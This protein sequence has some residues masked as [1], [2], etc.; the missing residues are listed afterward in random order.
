LQRFLLIKPR[1]G[2]RRPSPE[3][4]RA[5]R[6]R[7]VETHLESL[8]R[9]LRVRLPGT[10]PSDRRIATTGGGVMH[11][12]PPATQEPDTQRERTRDDDDDGE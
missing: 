4:F 12:S 2:D 3:I 5:A 9:A 8:P 10:L 1:S 11:D 6:E 7:G